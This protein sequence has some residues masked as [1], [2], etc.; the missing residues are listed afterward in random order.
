MTDSQVYDMQSGVYAGYGTPESYPS[1]PDVS[2]RLYVDSCDSRMESS[3]ACDIPPVTVSPFQPRFSQLINAVG[4]PLVDPRFDRSS[5]IVV[6]AYDMASAAPCVTGRCDMYENALGP[7]SIARTQLREEDIIRLILSANNGYLDQSRNNPA[8]W[9]NPQFAAYQPGRVPPSQVQGYD[10]A[11]A[12]VDPGYVDE[13]GM[14]PSSYPTCP[15]TMRPNTRNPRMWVTPDQ[16]WQ[17]QSC[18]NQQWLNAQRDWQHQQFNQNQR[19]QNPNW[20]YQQW[21]QNQRYQNQ[22]WQYQQWNQNQQWDQR[23]QWSR[24]GGYYPGYDSDYNQ[25]WQEQGCNPGFNPYSRWNNANMYNPGRGGND[26]LLQ[27]MRYA[28]FVLSMINQGNHGRGGYM[29]FNPGYGGYMNGYNSGFMNGGYYNGYGANPL[30]MIINTA[31][32]G[33]FRGGGCNQSYNQFNRH[34]QFNQMNRYNNFNRGYNG[35]GGRGAVRIGNF[36]IGF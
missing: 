22:N 13:R 18:Q 20:Q 2:R 34:N 6:P 14:C 36:S 15:S 17:D 33:G 16:Q 35:Y 1:Q 25:Q 5:Q 19:Y 21:S 24:P 23:Q 31:I 28:P 8:L 7:T 29:N 26:T 4:N 3:R 9:N 27:V 12:F 10:V 32:N 30:S 11:R